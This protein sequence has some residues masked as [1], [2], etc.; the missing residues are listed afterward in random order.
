MY[1]ALRIYRSK[2]WAGPFDH[3]TDYE[4][5]NRRRDETAFAL[6]SSHAV[7]V[8]LLG[9][10]TLFL[11]SI[12]SEKHLQRELVQVQDLR[13]LIAIVDFYHAIVHEIV[14]EPLELNVEDRR[15]RGELDS[16][17][18]ILKAMTLR[19]ILVIAFQHLHLNVIAE[20]CIKVGHT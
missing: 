13:E 19:L 17:F 4:H 5:F 15:E 1:R 18:R 14:F 3:V 7:K 20:G 10:S 9:D 6:F 2:G 8:V 12:C 11:G 16:L